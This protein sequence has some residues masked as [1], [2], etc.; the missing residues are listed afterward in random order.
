MPGRLPSVPGL[1]RHCLGAPTPQ[2]PLASSRQPALAPQRRPRARA[3]P[4]RPARGSNCPGDLAHDDITKKSINLPKFV[5]PLTKNQEILEY[6]V[7]G[8]REYYSHGFHEKLGIG[9]LLTP[10]FGQPRSR[11][12]PKPQDSRESDNIIPKCAEAPDEGTLKPRRKKS[13]KSQDDVSPDKGQTPDDE[14]LSRVH[15]GFVFAHR[16]C[17]GVKQ[18]SQAFVLNIDFWHTVSSETEI[19]VN[20]AQML[21][22]RPH[23]LSIFRVH[24]DLATCVGEVK[25][26]HGPSAFDLMKLTHGVT[27]TREHTTNPYIPI[28]AM[29]EARRLS[30]I[31]ELSNAYVAGPQGG[32]VNPRDY[33]GA[34]RATTWLAM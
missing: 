27:C 4:H 15:L 34:M 9:R 19:Y 8:R 18:T 6:L 28:D 16:T 12:R 32:H 22:S 20:N 1:S 29:E 31:P 17:T 26:L 5:S 30:W 13:P 7:Q 2:D 24:F 21:T 3:E 11:H 23:S 10:K 14:S 25:Q 33:P